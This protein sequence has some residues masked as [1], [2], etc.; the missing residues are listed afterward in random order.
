MSLHTGR[1]ADH[2]HGAVQNGQHPLCFRGKVH[3]T[4]SVHQGDGPVLGFQ[5]G[6]LGEDGNTPGAL[7]GVGVQIGIRVVHSAQGAFC[8]AYIQYGFGKGGLACVHMGKQAD[9]AWCLIQLCAHKNPPPV[10]M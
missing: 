1:C 10:E 2:Q 4:R 8:A 9:S 3:V 6:L 7:Q 5:K